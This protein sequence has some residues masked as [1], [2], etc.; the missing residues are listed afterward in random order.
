MVPDDRFQ[1]RDMD[2]ERGASWQMPTLSPSPL[3]IAMVQAPTSLPLFLLAVPVGALADIVNRRTLLLI[4]QEWMLAAA[5]ALSVTT[6]A[7]AMSPALL[8]LLTC[9]LGLETAMNRR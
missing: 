3:I 5:A 7:G 2:A 6:Y 4:T 9:L 8:L 1:R